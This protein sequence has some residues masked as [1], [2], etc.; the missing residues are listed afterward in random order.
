MDKEILDEIVQQHHRMPPRRHSKKI[1]I[2]DPLGTATRGERVEV[3][4]LGPSDEEHTFLQTHKFNRI[5]PRCARKIENA[6]R[7][8]MAKS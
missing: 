6:P 3:R 1:P 7:S 5:C 4:C 2:I 8:A